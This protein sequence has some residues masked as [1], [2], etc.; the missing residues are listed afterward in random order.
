MGWCECEIGF[1]FHPEGVGVL[2]IWVKKIK[3][4]EFI[5][6]CDEF[7]DFTSHELLMMIHKL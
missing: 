5:S 7:Q 6:S 4:P 1:L 3:Y 2:V